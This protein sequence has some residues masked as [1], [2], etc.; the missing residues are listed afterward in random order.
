MLCVKDGMSQRRYGTKLC[1]KMM[2]DKVIVTR[3]IREAAEWEEERRRSGIQNQKENPTQRC[4]KK[5]ISDK[6]NCSFPK[7]RVFGLCNVS[8]FG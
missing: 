8:G 7:N 4:E 6:E 5:M 2:C 1:V 3:Q